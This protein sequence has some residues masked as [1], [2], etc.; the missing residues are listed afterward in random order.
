[1]VAAAR[2]T[3][4]GGDRG[5]VV[6]AVIIVGVIAAVVLGGIW[7]QRSRSAPLDDVPVARVS[8]TYD[9]S[10]D[11]AV[12]VAGDPEAPVTVDVYEDFLCPACRIFEDRDA[13]KMEQALAA[14]SVRVRYHPLNLL[15]AQSNPAGYSLEAANAA[16]C[17]A[18][19]GQFPSFHKS[20]YGSQPREGGR[21]YTV[22][23]LVRLGGA[24]G[25]TGG[26]FESCVRDGTHKDAVRASLASA[27]DD[28]SLKRPGANG[29]PV[30]GTPT[31]TVGG[32]IVNLEDES[33]LDNAVRDG[34]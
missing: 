27:R 22:D 25:V 10:V 30:F 14:G 11:G 21:G 6:T 16:I 15:E 24:L 1:A 13:G 34:S 4:S 32:K 7:W 29:T 26:S 23:Q 19:A 3:S 9:V 2:R 33:W 12:V 31:V 18:D 17:A 20:L 5:R 8:A 28:A